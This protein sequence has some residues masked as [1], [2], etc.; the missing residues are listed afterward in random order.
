[1]QSFRGTV[2]NAEQQTISVAGML[3]SHSIVAGVQTLS[4]YFYLPEGSS[5]IGGKAPY[6]LVLDDGRSG[7]IHILEYLSG[8]DQRTR[9][10]FKVIGPLR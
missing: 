5:S 10:E 7:E 1:M 4:G 3:G 6:R 2:T 9:A 8:L